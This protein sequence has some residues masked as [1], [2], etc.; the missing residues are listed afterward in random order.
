MRQEPVALFHDPL[1]DQATS[2]EPGATGQQRQPERRPR[3]TT[4]RYADPATA[5]AASMEAVVRDLRTLER[6][7][8]KRNPRL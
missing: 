6:T 2:A 4:P 3:R 5:R 8:Y 1:A 7:T